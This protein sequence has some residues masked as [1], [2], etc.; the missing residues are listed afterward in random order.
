MYFS[1][2]LC[3]NLFNYVLYSARGLENTS[4]LTVHSPPAILSDLE[5]DTVYTVTLSTKI[6]NIYRREWKHLGNEPRFL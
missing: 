6:G 4:S 2:Y 5:P 1:F 3:M